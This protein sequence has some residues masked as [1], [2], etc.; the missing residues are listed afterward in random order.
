MFNWT[1]VGWSQ[2][3]AWFIAGMGATFSTQYVIQAINTTDDAR[4]AKIA[5]FSTAAFLVPFGIIT[6]M[7]GMCSLA[8]YPNIPSIKAFSVLISKMDGVMAGVVAAGLAASL[9][10]SLAAFSV[11]TAT[12]LYKDFY[13]GMIVKN[14]SEKNSL[15]FIRA[16]TIVMGLLPIILAIYT[17]NVLSMTFLGKA[18]RASLSVLVLFVFYMP[19]FGSKGGAFL[20]IVMSLIATIAWFMMGNPFGIDNA[21]VA[22]AVPLV[23]MTLSNLFKGT[24]EAAPAVAPASSSTT[25]NG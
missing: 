13:A 14:P 6:A 24:P 11:A 2:I 8:L 17:P 16:A 18:L 20:S 15:M 4:S 23:V 12:L 1:H 25:G 21:Y 19:A 10:G 7:V 9:F 5:S 3:L 22:L